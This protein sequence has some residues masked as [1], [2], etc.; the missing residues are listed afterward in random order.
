MAKRVNEEKIIESLSPDEAYT[1]LM[2]LLRE[3]PDLKNKIFKI[4]E[5]I[6]CD[7]DP[8]DIMDEV[9]SELNDL[10][11]EELWDRSGEN[12]YGYVDPGDESWVMMDEVLDPYIDEMK[13]YQERAMSIEAKQYCIGIIRG[14]RKYKIESHSE[15][16][17]WAVDAPE[18]KI[19][20]VFGEWKDGNPS[21]EDVAEVSQI[22]EEK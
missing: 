18:E 12:R 6:L 5:E 13:K 4:A 19:Q 14:I 3:N 20:S 8:E 1:A 2:I 16:L 7:V 22:L 9:Y 10:E 11:V 17:N 15:F 21:I